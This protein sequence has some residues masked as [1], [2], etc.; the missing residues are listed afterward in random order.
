M[1]E[2]SALA[3]K[4]EKRRTKRP[5][6]QQHQVVFDNREMREVYNQPALNNQMYDEQLNDQ[7]YVLPSKFEVDLRS[8]SL[9]TIPTS[10]SYEKSPSHNTTSVKNSYEKLEN[11]A[12]K[13]PAPSSKK[14]TVLPTNS[15]ISLYST[16]SEEPVTAIN[17]RSK[18][19]PD[20]STKHTGPNNGRD[21]RIPRK[22]ILRKQLEKNLQ[23]RNKSDSESE[24]KVSSVKRGTASHS[25]LPNSVAK[26]RVKHDR[27]G[28][29]HR[30]QQYR[31]SSTESQ[32][33]QAPRPHGT[34]GHSSV[35]N[36]NRIIDD[37]KHLPPVLQCSS[38][39]VP[40]VARRLAQGQSVRFSN[41]VEDIHNLR[42]NGIR[43]E[44]RNVVKESVPNDKP[45][46]PDLQQ[47]DQKKAVGVYHQDNEVK[48]EELKLPIITCANNNN[49]VST[50]PFPVI[51]EVTVTSFPSVS[52]ERAP[53]CSPDD[54]PLNIHHNEPSHRV[55]HDG[56]DWSYRNGV[57]SLPPIKEVMSRE[58]RR[59]GWNDALLPA[60][61]ILKNC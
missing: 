42:N 50:R 15:Q 17:R 45:K 35:R 25:Q 14:A 9:H 47:N 48:A 37:H 21:S 2:Q 11:K 24:G 55:A 58:E 59:V 38:P 44:T 49:S 18:P 13:G 19:R 51:P 52:I 43:D 6:Q 31:P 23:D 12:S 29:G 8:P 57:C 39:P 46:L 20:P 27:S 34:K 56:I 36:M 61:F 30:L 60:I 10:Q 26:S 1:A 5:P 41:E 54:R 32:E 22:N 53:S 33:D 28:G 40:A 4:E 7:K 16:S 3:A